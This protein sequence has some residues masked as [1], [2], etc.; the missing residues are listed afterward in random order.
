MSHELSNA[1]S[2]K[3]SKPQQTEDGDLHKNLPQMHP[4]IDERHQSHTLQQAE[5]TK[6]LQ[7]LT[8]QLAL[9]EELAAQLMA[10]MN[11]MSSIHTDYENSMKD[12]QQQ[13][14]GLQKERDVLMHVLQSV[15]NNNSSKISE[16]R[17][18]RLQEL[19]QKISALSKKITEQEKIIKM[20]E[21]ND[22]KITQLNKEIQGMKQAKVKLI[23]QMR[24]EN[25][26]F[27]SWKQEREKEL[28]QLRIQDRRRQNEMARMDRLH[29][30]QQNV[31]KR[32][33]EEAAAVN[34]CLKD[35]LAVQKSVQER[36]LQQHGTTAK[37]QL[38]IDQELEVL[39]STVDAE[40]TLE[41]LLED[42]AMLHRQLDQLKA[43]LEQND[44]GADDRI[45]IEVDL[46]QL[47]KDTD[48]RTYSKR[49]LI[50]IRKI[51]QN[52][53][54]YCTVYGRCQMCT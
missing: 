19:E 8:Q 54:G 45:A 47:Q 14:S 29:T 30:K 9:K 11:H 15:Q 20:K 12:L 32:K 10:N 21:K 4:D 34:K 6:E 24:S 33:V 40:K 25:E 49:F 43:Q 7:E 23:R 46:K 13:I 44:I 18:K 39:V 26:R 51:K 28:I 36:Q 2:H 50:L 3:S 42:R 17:R 31:L 41:Q 37:I 48:L 1:V 52:P 16:R 35:A 53:V 5:R 38:W 27:R 22:E